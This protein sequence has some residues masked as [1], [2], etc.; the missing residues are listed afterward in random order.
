MYRWMN[1][2]NVIGTPQGC[3]TCLKMFQF[4][5]TCPE[6]GNVK[7]TILVL[8]PG[9]Q[10]ITVEMFIVMYWTLVLNKENKSVR[11]GNLI[12]TAELL[13]QTT[14]LYITVEKQCA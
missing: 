5:S 2:A 9:H 8:D 6:Q 11:S 1:K 14:L 12:W 13:S 4:I 10:W 3:C 7:S